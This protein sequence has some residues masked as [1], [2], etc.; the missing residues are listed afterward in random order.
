MKKLF[1]V[2]STQSKTP[3]PDLFF[4]DKR[5][6]KEKRDELNVAANSEKQFVVTPGPD[7]WKSK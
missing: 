3:L 7:H 1:A 5:A 6:A 4:S 2:R